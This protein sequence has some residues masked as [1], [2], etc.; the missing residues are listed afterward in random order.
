[1]S[2]LPSL[3]RIPVIGSGILAIV[4]AIFERKKN[5]C[6][7][8]VLEANQVNQVLILF[9]KEYVRKM[10]I[11]TMPANQALQ[12]QALLKES[13]RKKKIKT[14][15]YYEMQNFYLLVFFK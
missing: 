14:N 4:Q 3:E 9:L 2:N 15:I 6:F 5:L 8:Q 1:L 13:M 12:V 10:R 7:L 11:Q